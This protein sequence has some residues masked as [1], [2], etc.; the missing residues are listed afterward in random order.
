MGSRGSGSTRY[1]E[2]LAARAKVLIEGYDNQY[3]P[4]CFSILIVIHSLTE[5]PA[6][7][8][9]RVAKSWTCMK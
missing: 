7:P 4:M 9:Y 2:E 5:K 8:V 6:R 1:S 3:W